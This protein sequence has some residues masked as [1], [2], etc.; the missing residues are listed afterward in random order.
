MPVADIMIT[1]HVTDLAQVAPLILRGE[2]G[3]LRAY[4]GDNGFPWVLH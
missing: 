1:A 3:D 2:P 4:F